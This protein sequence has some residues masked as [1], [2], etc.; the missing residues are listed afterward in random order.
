MEGNTGALAQQSRESIAN[1]ENCGRVGAAF[2]GLFENSHLGYFTLLRCPIRTHSGTSSGLDR[3]NACCHLRYVFVD[4]FRHFWVFHGL[5]EHVV[6]SFR[7]HDIP[8][9]GNS[10]K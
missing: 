4:E 6:K 10:R 9:C 7:R 3:L 8:P 2:M 5:I 1:R